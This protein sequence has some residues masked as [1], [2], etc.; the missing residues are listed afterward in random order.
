MLTASAPGSTRTGGAGDDTLKASQ[1]SDRLT[2]GGGADT[3]IFA[4]TPWAPAQITDFAVGSDRLDMTALFRQAGYA[5]TDPIADGYVSLLDDGAGGTKLLFD[6][7]A[8][9]SG[10]AWASYIIQLDNLA[11]NSLTWA[12]LTGTGTTGDALITSPAGTGSLFRSDQYADELTGTSG[13]DTLIAGQGPD[14]LAGGTGADVFVFEA[15]PWNAGVIADFEVGIDVLNLRALFT[16]AGYSGQDPSAEGYL[17]FRDAGPDTAVYFDA[18]GTGHVWPSL[19]TVLQRVSPGE[20]DPR[21]W[22]F[23]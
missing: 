14:T 10:Q 19:V 17:E 15:I 4:T 16:A 23:Q 18:D 13:A 1:G 8:A 5:G 9:G 11:A 6:A 7:D 22:L 20:L 21:D 2:G 12:K 3:F